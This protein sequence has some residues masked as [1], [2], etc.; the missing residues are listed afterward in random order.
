MISHDRLNV[1]SPYRVHD[2]LQLPQ[3]PFLLKWKKNSSNTNNEIIGI[4]KGRFLR[5]LGFITAAT[6]KDKNQQH[7]HSFDLLSREYKR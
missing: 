3:P 6:S 7:E 2:S 1:G 5:I 4:V